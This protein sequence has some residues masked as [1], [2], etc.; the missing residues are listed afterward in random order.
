LINSVLIK[1][2]GVFHSS[3]LNNRKPNHPLMALALN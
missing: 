2:R 1:Y 3:P